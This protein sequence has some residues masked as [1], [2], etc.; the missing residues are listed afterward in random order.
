MSGGGSGVILARANAAAPV[1]AEGDLAP[2]SQD[3]SARLRVLATVLG[4]T[5]TPGDAIVIPTDAIDARAWLEL[6][7]G[8]T[9]S[10]A[11]GRAWPTATGTETASVAAMETIGAIVG[12]NGAGGINRLRISTVG[13]AVCVPPEGEINAD[14]DNGDYSATA[15]WNAYAVQLGHVETSLPTALTNGRKSRVRLDAYGQQLVTLGMPAPN[16]RNNP[17]GTFIVD[18]NDANIAA[19]ARTLL[20]ITVWSTEAGG[21]VRYLQIHDK[22]SALAGGDTPI[23]GCSWRLV[24]GSGAGASFLQI[25]G[26]ELGPARAIRTGNGLRV[27]WSSTA[28]T[29]T[30]AATP[31]VEARIIFAT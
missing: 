5:K 25:V 9:G 19:A 31:K 28:A 26:D 2:L 16:T 22:A 24:G 20:G 15:L 29:Y 18:S 14:I 27:G 7:V 10:L 13:G 30:A 23:A 1:L 6:L 11:R 4:G 8:A 21:V 17:S 3:L 12:P